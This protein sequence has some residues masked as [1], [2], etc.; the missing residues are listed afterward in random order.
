M[1]LLFYLIISYLCHKIK[2]MA[3]T[4]NQLI[5]SFLEHWQ[6]IRKRKPETVRNYELYLRRWQ[7]F[8]GALSLA[9]LTDTKL[10][11]YHRWLQ[12]QTFGGKKLSA[13]TI[14][15]HFIALRNWLRYLQ[16]HQIKTGVRA[17]P[18][19]TKHISVPR[20]KIT[21][22]QFNKILQTF[23]LYKKDS[24]LTRLRDELLL[25][26]LY[27]ARCKVHEL[28]S[29][30]RQNLTTVSTAVKRVGQHYLRLRHDEVEALWLAH[31]RA[32]TQRKKVKALSQRSAQ[33]LIRKYAIMAGLPEI[34]AD[35][36]SR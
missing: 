26:Y 21:S 34:T 8:Y 23:R 20:S 1:F 5:N 6:Y 18:K 32:Q 35:S 7:Q 29:M 12:H 11:S 28:V 15:Y 10:E 25:L 24:L 30:T 4:T 31:D 22:S 27:E 14:N 33:R 36:F 16:L 2:V 19:L 9:Q 3:Y 17:R 13:N